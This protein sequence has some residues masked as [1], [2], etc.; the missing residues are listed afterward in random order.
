MKQ[1]TE[2][3][4]I[5]L[6]VL[7]VSLIA[8]ACCESVRR[9]APTNFIFLGLFTIAQAFMLGTMTSRVSADTVMIAIGATAGITV[10]LT[11]FAFQVSSG[12]PFKMFSILQNCSQIS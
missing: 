10:G 8:M 4:W 11:L 7:F 9:T 2:L 3:F 6:V 5:S 1:H 12:L